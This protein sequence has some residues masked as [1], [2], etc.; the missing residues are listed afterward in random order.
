MYVRGR[1]MGI[2]AGACPSSQQLQG[3]VDYT[4][5]CQAA[6]APPTVIDASTNQPVG[7]VEQAAYN[8]A[9]YSGLLQKPSAPTTT[10][11]ASGLMPWLLGGAALLVGLAVLRGGR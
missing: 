9:W 5:P 8:L 11:T 2:A 3:I 10:P 1:G 4:D 7:P 6:A